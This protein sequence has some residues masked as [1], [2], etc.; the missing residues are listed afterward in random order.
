MAEIIPSILV[1]TSAEFNE[2]L[3]Q[4]G[5]HFSAFHLD[6][7]DGIFVPNTTIEGFTELER[8]DTDLAV[9]A[10]LMVSKPENHISRWL[11][12]NVERIIFHVEATDKVMETIAA[13]K[14]GDCEAGIALNPQ[15]P[16]EKIADYMEAVDFVHFM[17]VEPGFYG[18]PFVESVI[19]K[20]K[21]FHYFYPDKL[22]SVDGH[23][24]TETAPQLVA[25][26]ASEL[27]VGHD[28]F[29]G[30]SVT[31]ELAKLK[32]VL[33]PNFQWQMTNQTQSSNAKYLDLGF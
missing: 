33:N 1:K 10:H 28:L 27:V 16:I 11:E 23:V 24:D 26:G 21:E 15:T 9:A 2:K 17:T 29:D 4:I 30:K 13:I 18:S 20:I 14:D 32:A 31:E 5:G 22:I 25:A 8:S 6:I 7:A 12:T 19:E 3:S